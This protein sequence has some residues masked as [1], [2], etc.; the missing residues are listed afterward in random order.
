MWVTD[1]SGV[2][3]TDVAANCHE[4]AGSAGSRRPA[5]HKERA[6][7]TLNGYRDDDIRAYVYRTDDLGKNFK[8]ISK[9]LPDEA[10]NVI[11]EDPVVEDVLYV[12]TDRGVYV[13]TR[14]R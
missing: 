3:W 8:D 12:G 13:S 6:Y 7:V 10:V 4:S 1:S 9:G 14:W 11:R 2:R 5:T